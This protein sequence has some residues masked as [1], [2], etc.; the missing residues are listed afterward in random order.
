M[1]EAKL[2]EVES[3]I[4]IGGNLINNLRCADDTKLLAETKEGLQKI[5]KNDSS[6]KHGLY[7]NLKKT[8]VMATEEI[9]NFNI[10]N[11]K[12][13]IVNKF[14]FLGTKIQ[15][16]GTCDGEIAC[17]L[18]LGRAA[19]SGLTKIWRSKDIGTKTKIRILNALVFP[20]N[21]GR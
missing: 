19:M 8:N 17:R 4:K 10:D 12:V 18:A 16:A 9:T 1:R 14:I 3:G 15:N 11:E 13:E 7:L 2:D 21:H 5:F 6:V 20:V